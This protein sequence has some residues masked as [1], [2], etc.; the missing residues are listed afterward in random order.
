MNTQTHPQKML[1]L[2]SR[3]GYITFLMH[4]SKLQAYHGFSIMSRFRFFFS[5]SVVQNP[6]LSPLINVDIVPSINKTIHG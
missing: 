2:A 5:S 4:D 3:N 1:C 6:T